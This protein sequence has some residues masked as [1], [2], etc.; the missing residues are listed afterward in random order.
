VAAYRQGQTLSAFVSL[1]FFALHQTFSLA[2]TKFD[3]PSSYVSSPHQTFS[4]AV[5]TSDKLSHNLPQLLALRMSQFKV[6]AVVAT[7]PLPQLHQQNESFFS[8]N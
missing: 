6:T 7:V 3:K 5:T 4:L 1:G 2:V 8:L